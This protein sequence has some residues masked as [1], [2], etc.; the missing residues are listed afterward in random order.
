M[1]QKAELVAASGFPSSTTGFIT[2]ILLCFLSY[3]FLYLDPACIP[4]KSRLTYIA[5]ARQLPI[6]HYLAENLM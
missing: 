2:P 1:L 6:Q 5:D 3:M 4:N